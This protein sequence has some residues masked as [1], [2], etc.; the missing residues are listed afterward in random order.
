MAGH[1]APRMD[2]NS[3][4]SWDRVSAHFLQ[5]FG[6]PLLR[7]R[8]F[9]ESDNETSALV[10]VVN[11]AFVK[12]F[13][14]EGEDPIGQ[15]FGLDKPEFAN[16]FRIVGVVGDAKFAGWGLRRPAMPMFFVP[17]TQ[18]VAY[19]AG[20]MLER[21]E[22]RSHYIGG[23]MLTTNAAA[24]GLEPVITKILADLIR[25]GRSRVSGR[26]G[27]SGGAVRPDARGE[28]GGPVY[29]SHSL[30]AVDFTA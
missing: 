1:P 20:D 21:V 29:G 23:L 22:R 26:C 9:T 13:F 8:H 14:R 18:L 10:A 30:A 3:G 25:P 12:R 16:T 27:T 5:S 2:D 4:A 11:Q 28:P 15:Q 17:L 19:P 6:I 24:G 7:G